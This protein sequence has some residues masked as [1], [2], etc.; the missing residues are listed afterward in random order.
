MTID[1]I[2]SLISKRTGISFEHFEE[3][4]E[5]NEMWQYDGGLGGLVVQVS[6]YTTTLKRPGVTVSV[7]QA[8]GDEDDWEGDAQNFRDEDWFDSLT[9]H[10]VN[11]L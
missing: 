3:D 9:N 8:N 11:H 5:S 1:Q 4:E 10:I 6:S 2:I 7:I